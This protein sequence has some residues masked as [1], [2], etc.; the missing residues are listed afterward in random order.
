MTPLLS[1]LH[2]SGDQHG[3]N[4]KL[5][6]K[7]DERQIISDGPITD[8]DSRVRLSQISVLPLTQCIYINSAKLNIICKLQ[9]QMMILGFMNYTETSFAL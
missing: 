6:A 5:Q 7:R 3:P 8:E 1:K 2:T 4:V 9:D